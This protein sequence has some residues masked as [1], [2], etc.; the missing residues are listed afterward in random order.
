MAD[1]GITGLDQMAALIRR[2]EQMGMSITEDVKDKAL[3]A[4]AEIA[5][6][7]IEH[8]P[9]MPISNK[10]KEHARDHLIIEKV[11]DGQFDIGV[12]ND[13][14]YLLF[15]EIGA[16]GGTYKVS[17]GKTYTT[18]NTPAKPFMRPAFE[19]NQDE[20][21]QAMADIIR[22]ELGLWVL[23]LILSML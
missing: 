13:F 7:K 19:S 10:N 11:K 3:Q 2:I 23:I 21:E 6:D 1:S 17:N 8:H 9:N 18:P 15:H 5:K 22:R 12:E 14:F 4:G 16:E 20:I